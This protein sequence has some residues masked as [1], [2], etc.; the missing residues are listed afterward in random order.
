MPRAVYRSSRRVARQFPRPGGETVISM[1]ESPAKILGASLDASPGASPG[2][3][4]AAGRSP[5]GRDPACRAMRSNAASRRAAASS[6]SSVSPAMPVRPPASAQLP[7]RL[8]PRNRFEVKSVVSGQW[9]AV[10]DRY[11]AVIVHGL[12]DARLALSVGLTVTL[13][14]A[15][16]AAL[17]AGC[18]WWRALVQRQARDRDPRLRRRVRTGDGGDTHGQRGLLH[19]GPAFAAVSAAAAGSAPSCRVRGPARSTSPIAGG[20][21][22]GRMA[23][24]R[25]S[26]E[27]GSQHVKGTALRVRR[28]KDSCALRNA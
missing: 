18:G 9:S 17:Y 14:S 28:R 25:T 24:A 27:G 22:A 8:K 7:R 20:A 11:P 4:A 3:L 16:G 10:S 15:P 19:P 23:A 6:G 1:V 21:T 5:A 12:G 26:P 2:A 13:L